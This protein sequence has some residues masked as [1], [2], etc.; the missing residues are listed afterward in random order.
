MVHGDIKPDNILVTSY[1]WVMITDISQKP[2]LLMDDDLKRYNLYFG[3]LENN[4]R[5][6]IAPERWYS[7]G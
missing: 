2:A 3:Y 1:D 5:A 7:P 6:Y 4:L